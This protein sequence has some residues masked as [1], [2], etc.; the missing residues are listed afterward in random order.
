MRTRFGTDTTTNTMAD[1]DPQQLHKQ[2]LLRRLNA[3]FDEVKVLRTELHS[4][5]DQTRELQC[6]MVQLLA[7]HNDATY[8]VKSH[9]EENALLRKSVDR[10]NEDNAFLRVE[11]TKI[12]EEFSNLRIVMPALP[13]MD[14]DDASPA[15]LQLPENPAGLAP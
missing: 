13:P 8:I 15:D 1:R 14:L 4:L 6:K 2:E 12:R 11:V 9:V 10:L 7:L 5:Q 3:K